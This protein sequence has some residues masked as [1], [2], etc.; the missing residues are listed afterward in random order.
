[1]EVIYFRNHRIYVVCPSSGLLNSK[2]IS[3]S[4]S[5]KVTIFKRWTEISVTPNFSKTSTCL[6]M[7]VSIVS[8]KQTNKLR[9]P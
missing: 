2:T 1:M 7:N 5:E 8:Y 9:G 6:W 4:Q 3:V